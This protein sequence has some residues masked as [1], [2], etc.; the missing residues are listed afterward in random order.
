MFGW[1]KTK[2]HQKQVAERMRKHMATATGPPLHTG[3]IAVAMAALDDDLVQKELSRIRPDQ[4]DVFMMTYECIVMWAILRGFALAGLPEPA[5][6]GVLSAMRDH[7]AHHAFYVPEQFEMIWDE[8]QEW[9]PVFAKPPKDGLY[10]PATAFV[11]IPHAAGSRLDFIPD[12][13]FQIHVI[14][15]IDSVTDIGKFAAQQELQQQA[16]TPGS[17]LDAALEPGAIL[18]AGFYRRF[19]AYNN[20][21]PTAKT[22]DR[23]IIEIYS[24]VGSAFQE[25]AKQRGEHIPA[26]FVNRIVS[27]FLQMYEKMGENFM[28]EHLRYEVNKYLR[29]G[30][31]PDYRQ[32][33]PFF[34]DE[35]MEVRESSTRRRPEPCMNPVQPDDKLAKVVGEKALPR[36][37][38]TKILWVYIRKN[39]LQDTKDRNLIHADENLKA[40]FNGKKLVNVSE[41]TELV[42]GHLKY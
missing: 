5:K 2:L 27:G 26:E 29:E 38:L 39:G 34:R 12:M 8:T 36:T 33:L 15:T 14:Y 19:G 31:R 22:S 10:A 20:C 35:E 17:V 40:V 41:L 3:A 24:L 42:S 4:R 37:E 1:L 28:Q 23:T 11:Q 6:S 16:P 25:A 9:M 32:P 18:I 21:P 7:F 13:M 30:L